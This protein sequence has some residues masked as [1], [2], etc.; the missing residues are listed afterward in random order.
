MAE[1]VAFKFLPRAYQVRLPSPHRGAIARTD[2][3][4]AGRRHPPTPPRPR[5]TSPPPDAIADDLFS[6][7]VS[8]H[9][10]NDLRSCGAAGNS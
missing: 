1:A 6:L 7:S 8:R 9:P 3:T 4:E 2:G 10:S 5:Q